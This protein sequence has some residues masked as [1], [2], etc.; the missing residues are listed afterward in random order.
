MSAR[1]EWTTCDPHSETDEKERLEREGEEAPSGC[2][3]GFERPNSEAHSD[4]SAEHE[5]NGHDHAETRLSVECELQVLDPPL[6]PCSPDDTCSGE[7]EDRHTRDREQGVSHYLRL[8]ARWSR[9]VSVVDGL[10]RQLPASAETLDEPRPAAQTSRGSRPAT[11]V[12]QRANTIESPRLS[13]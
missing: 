9:R 2:E 1:G 4:Y 10:P 8:R 12:S 7:H 5:K 3:A 6:V 13:S 11:F